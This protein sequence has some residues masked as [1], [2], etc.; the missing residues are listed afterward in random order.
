[1]STS[2]KSP[3]RVALAALAVARDRLPAYAHRFAPKKYTQPQLFACLVLK[4]F[5]RTD[6]RGIVAILADNPTL[7]RTI[8]LEAVPHFTTLQKAARRLLTLAQVRRLLERSVDLA[9]GRRRHVKLAAIDSTGLETGHASRY[10]V[11]RRERGQKTARNPLYQTTT[12]RRFTKLG[13]ISDTR[14]HLVLTVSA[15]RGPKPDVVELP[16]LVDRLPSCVTVHHLLADAGY[17]SEA[18]HVY[19]RDYHGITTAIPPK[20]GRPTDKAP[21]GRYRRLMFHTL[22]RRPYGQRWQVEMH[23]SYCLLCHRFYHVVGRGLGCVKS[24][25]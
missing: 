2:S 1:M 13:I 4:R 5:H 17:D 15:G 21:T 19:A 24:A 12:Y 14:S 8:G 7:C 25:A 23:Q 22:S 20:I 10:Y 11:R 6:Y 18:N 3:R 16:L 9:M